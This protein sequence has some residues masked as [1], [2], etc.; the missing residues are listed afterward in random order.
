MTEEVGLARSAGP[1]VGILHDHEDLLLGRVAAVVGKVH[2]LFGLKHDAA[3]RFK[4]QCESKGW[5][6]LSP[7]NDR[8]IQ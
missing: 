6:V 5:G 7:L 2:D 8:E 4:N 3:W 1:A